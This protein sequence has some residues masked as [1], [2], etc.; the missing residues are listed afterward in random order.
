MS[1]LKYPIFKAPKA[2]FE[3]DRQ[4]ML[5]EHPYRCT[6]TLIFLCIPG[7][8]GMLNRD[9]GNTQRA[10]NLTP[11]ILKLVQGPLEILNSQD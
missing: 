2:E 10:L 1:A 4:A 8:G 3:S 7:Y 5:G 11:S 6:C 9:H